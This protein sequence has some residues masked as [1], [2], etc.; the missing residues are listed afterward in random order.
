MG[1][2]QDLL[3]EVPLAAVLR[4]RVAL[5]D[6]KYEAAMQRVQELE[7]KVATLE[8]QAADLRAQ[9]PSDE[10]RSISIETCAVLTHMFRAKD[11][12]ARDV[13]TMANALGMEKS[14]LEYHLDRLHEAGFAETSGGNY[15]HGHV[16]W[17][18]LPAGRRYAVE[19]KL[20]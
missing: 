20:V 13:G 4:E 10:Q 16:Y 6:Q 17:A 11:L 14:A 2:I 3:Q 19:Q 12:N 7:Q 15:L 9:I 8:R 18:L 1:S 5:A